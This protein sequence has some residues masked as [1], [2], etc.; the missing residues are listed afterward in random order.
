ME[1]ELLAPA[2]R[3]RGQRLASSA[4]ASRVSRRPRLAPRQQRSRAE[5]QN[6]AWRCSGPGRR[7]RG[8]RRRPVPAL[9][10][11][12]QEQLGPS[13]R[14]T[15]PIVTGR[16]VDPAP[17]RHRGVVSQRFLDSRGDEVRLPGDAGPP[18]RVLQQP[19]HGVADQAGGGL[20]PGEGQREQDGGDLLAGKPG[21]GPRGGWP[22]G[23]WSGRRPAGRPAGRPGR[24]GNA[25]TRPC[26]WRSPPGRRAPGAPSRAPHGTR[27]TA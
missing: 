18:R 21:P 20:V 8:R 2:S 7:R 14:S 27:T 5:R 12:P 15:P 17:H 23:R 16:V 10:R 19:A 26:W 25:G 22:A 24:A 1:G 9:R 13:G 4:S 11:Q 3:S 6:A